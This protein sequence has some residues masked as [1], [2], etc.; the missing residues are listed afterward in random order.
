MKK[1]NVR[2]T[3]MFQIFQYI[4]QHIFFVLLSVIFAAI[5]VVLTLYVPILIGN[6]VDYMVAPGN[7]EFPQIMFYLKKILICIAFTGLAQ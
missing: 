4:K 3:T 2:N 7:V 6:A 1:D 5:S